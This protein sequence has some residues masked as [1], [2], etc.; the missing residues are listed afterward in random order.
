MNGRILVGVA[1]LAFGAL[2]AL[3]RARV[4]DFGSL[5]STYWP[6]ILIGIG[7]FWI[8]QPGG[9]RVAG[10]I[11][12]L[13]G[14]VF[15]VDRLRLFRFDIGDFLVPAILVAIG[16]VI[17]LGGTRRFGEP[18]PATTRADGSLQR[19]AIF[20]GANEKVVG[21]FQGAELSATFGGVELDLREATLPP[22]GATVVATALF[23]GVKVVVPRGWNVRA[24]GTPLFGGFENK[25]ESTPS[26]PVLDVRG[27]A[28]FGGVEISHEPG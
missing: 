24:S 13:V 28:T 14:L 3:D 8:T 23:G 18:R 4:L 27:S 1:L 16:L 15:Q 6:L 11:V 7:L 21:E 19:T 10:A 5:A 2:L 22:T 25:A 20:G 9:P 26:G 17:L 12:L